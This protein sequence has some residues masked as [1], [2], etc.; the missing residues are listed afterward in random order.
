[1][2]VYIRMFIIQEATRGFESMKS[3]LMDP[4][5]IAKLD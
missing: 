1:M 5:M 4:K 2:S 3:T